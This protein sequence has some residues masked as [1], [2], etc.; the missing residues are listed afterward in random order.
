VGFEY[1][2]N[3]HF[4]K[5]QLKKFHLLQKTSAAS[6]KQEEEE[7]HDHMTGG[8]AGD[9]SFIAQRS[10]QTSQAGGGG[11]AR[12]GTNKINIQ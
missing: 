5:F 11:A 7:V 12:S 3:L 9:V 1:L 8:L 4:Y 6:N 2:K 10:K